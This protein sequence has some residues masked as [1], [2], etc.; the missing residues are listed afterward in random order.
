[1]SFCDDLK[2]WE[3]MSP[4]ERFEAVRGWV[5]GAARDAGFDAGLGVRREAPPGKPNARGGYNPDTDTIHLHPD[6]FQDNRDGGWK[7]AFDTAV[8]EFAHHVQDEVDD[9]YGVDDAGDDDDGDDGDGGEEGDDGESDAAADAGVE[10]LHDDERHEESQDFA[11]AFLEEAE[12][13]CR[14]DPEGAE[15]R[16]KSFLEDWLLG[17]DAEPASEPSP[18]GDWNLPPAGVTYA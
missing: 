10:D 13:A 18:A 11:D 9:A 2:N 1:M 14:D 12:D 6:L 8:H 7:Y 16:L 4:G 3:D 15:S 17:R 5:D